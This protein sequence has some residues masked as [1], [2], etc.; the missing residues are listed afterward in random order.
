MKICV[1]TSGHD[2][3]DDRI[4]YK[5]ILSLKKKYSTIY[6]VAPGD[7]DFITQDGIIVKTFPK[8][9]KWYHRISIIKQMYKIATTINADIYH[10]HE[11]DSFQVAV[12]LKKHLGCKIIYD[13]HEYHPEGFAEHFPLCRGIITKII[14]QYEK[15]M[16]QRADY[17]I[18]VNS[19]LVNK[20][21]KYN[22]NVA[23]IPNYPVMEYLNFEKEYNKKPTF[24]YVGGLRE[25]RGI[26]KI[27]EAISLINY[28]YKYYFVGPFENDEFKHK[29]ENFIDS[30]MKKSDVVF[31]GK[32]S[33]MEVFKYLKKS[34]VGFVLLQAKNWRYVNS[35]PV[36]LFEYMMGKNA[37]IGSNFPMMK[38]IIEKW[39]V[40]LVIKPDSVEAIKEAIEIMGEN[41]SD[42][43]NMG[44]RG[45][46]AVEM[47]YNWDKCENVLLDIYSK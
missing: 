47:E 2:V 11:P 39:Q 44:A 12:K 7:K 45:L 43:N 25:D 17:I 5:E 41:I 34:H 36:K 15:K 31:T 6:L 26:F 4:Y 16:A 1:L 35:E 19:I 37:I 30:N 3:F 46:K 10:A 38:N 20:F 13:S 40:G 33:H 42:T 14:Y 22:S 9:K 29:V 28:D 24:I 32:I 23:L 8:R 27:L 18:T 21:K